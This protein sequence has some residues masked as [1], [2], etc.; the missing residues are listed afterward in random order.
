MSCRGDPTGGHLASSGK[1]TNPG[2]N[3][4]WGSTASE[5]EPTPQAALVAELGEAHSKVYQADPLVC[6]G[7]GGRLK[8]V[9]YVSDEVSIRRILDPP[10]PQPARAG[11]APATPGVIRVPVDDEGREI[12]T[13]CGQP[14]AVL[15]LDALSA[16]GVVSPSDVGSD[17]EEAQRGLVEDPSGAAAWL[18]PES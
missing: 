14:P 15:D 13:D 4:Q 11:Q 17:I 5:A 3:S 6:K 16:K 7:S 9:A 12:E 8:I 18:A 1:P 10:G 2:D